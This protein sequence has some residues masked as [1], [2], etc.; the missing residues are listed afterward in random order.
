MKKSL[1][2]R[3]LKLI[4]DLV[5]YFVT[6]QEQYKRALLSIQ[7]YIDS[8]DT[9]KNLIHSV[10][11]RIKDPDHL[12]DKLIRKAIEA[13]EKRKQFP[14]NRKN[15]FSKINDLAGYRIIHLHTKQ[16]KEIKKLILN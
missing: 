15:L 4:D 7:G 12:K 5:S 1:G 16:F 13:R 11:S 3:Q 8:S 14:I 6:N 2:I 9:L 10:K